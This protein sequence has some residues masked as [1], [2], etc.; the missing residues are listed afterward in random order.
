MKRILPIALLCMCLHAFAGEPVLNNPEDSVALKNEGHR[1][2]KKLYIG[3]KKED[4]L[5]VNHINLFVDSIRC[6]LHDSMPYHDWVTD[7]IHFRKYD[8]SKIQ[9]TLHLTLNDSS[10]HFTP[11]FRGEITSEFGRRSWRYHYGIDIDLNKGDSVRVAFTGKVRVSTYSKTYGNVVVVRHD[12]GLETLYAHLSK[13]LVDVDSVINTGTII[14]LGG[15]TG[16]SYGSHLH[17]EVRYFDEPLDPR[18]VIAFEDFS[19]HKDVLSISQCNFTYKDE[20]KVMGAIK[21]HR[22]KSGNTLSYIAVKY[23]TTIST[24]CRLNGISRTSILQIG[25]RLRVR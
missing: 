7:D 15:N 16:R 8:F 24:L 18:D 2:D 14:G 10:D 13:R 5:M 4:V 23:G 21:Y 20:L 6:T 1:V 17:F 3:H 9:D 19:T 12:N 22:V 11:P 25:Q